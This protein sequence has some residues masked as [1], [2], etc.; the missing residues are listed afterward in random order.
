M[1]LLRELQRRNVIR[2]ATAYVVTAW[3]I[4]Q[5]IETIFPAFGF[6]DEAV[7]LVVIAFAIGFVP[8]VILAWVFEW[9]PQ[10][11]RKD[12]GDI[13]QGPANIAMARR[14]DRIVMLI[15][16]LAVTFFIVERVLRP[17]PLDIKPAIVVL[18]FVGVD[19]KSDAEHLPMAVAEGLYTSLARIPQLVVSAWPTVN[20]L[21]Q[22]GLAPD[23]IVAT[24]KAAN[25]LSGTIEI[26][27]ERLRLVV[28]IVESESG[29]TIWQDSYE[30]T[31]AE[32]F[33]FQ[34]EIVAAAA[35][36]L[37]LGS[38]GALHRPAY[39]DPE[40]VRLTWQAWSASMRVNMPNQ[41]SVVVELL[42]RA[43]AV[44]PDYP[45]ALL[46]L[47]LA[48]YYLY[49][50]EGRTEEEANAAYRVLMDRVFAIDHEN[51]QA[52]AYKAW[53][54]FW[55]DG[56]AGHANHHLQVALRTALNDPESL[57]LLA[58]FARRTGNAEAAIWF[59][60][61]AV[62]ID[63]TC[64]NCIWQTTENLFYARRYEEA[65]EAK[66]VIQA[67]GGGGYAHHAFMLLSLDKPTE[68][69]ELLESKNAN[70]IQDVPLKAMAWHL[71]GDADKYAESVARIDQSG[72]PM[73]PFFLAE[74]YAFTGDVD[75][76]FA[77][78]DAAAEAGD[79][80]KYQLFLPHWE[81]L[82]GD[83]RWTT[84]RERLGMSEEK[85]AMLDFSP[86]FQYER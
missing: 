83:P 20:R 21:A 54:L 32:I 42:E 81:K 59:G 2:V 18:P 13:E 4:I 33:S 14:W 72:S 61:R 70:D 76:A 52:N 11:I 80:L 3:L 41:N 1:S 26:E 12:D 74:I 57:R 79:E 27:D 85:V 24:L 5:V 37:Q 58:G 44:D 50:E 66:K 55:D 34:Y 49:R 30:G 45:P 46:A 60:E 25:S 9:T 51:G 69:L 23:E 62:A 17:P 47:A 16:A 75:R 10:G 43:L 36:N 28:S 67:F 73:A 31:T 53:E 65:M 19:L 77:A 6:G 78:L 48:R 38:T 35:E 8:V 82:S 15:L 71:L 7:R 22:E 56:D 29:Q 86:V 39:H 64:E 63:P 84:L 40:A 68:A